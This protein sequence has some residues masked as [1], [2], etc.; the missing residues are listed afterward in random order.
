[1]VP[2][3]EEERGFVFTVKKSRIPGLTMVAQ[4]MEDKRTSPLTSNCQWIREGSCL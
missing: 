3:K 2:K 4:C 1:M